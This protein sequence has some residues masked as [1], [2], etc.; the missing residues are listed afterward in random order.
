MTH[1][2][3]D[4]VPTGMGRKLNPVFKGPFKVKNGLPNRYVIEDL[5]S[6]RKTL[7][8]VAVDNIKPWLITN[9][10]PDQLFQ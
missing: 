1:R 10:G 6:N 5:R 7:M 8:V 4:N 2:K 9:E 3:S